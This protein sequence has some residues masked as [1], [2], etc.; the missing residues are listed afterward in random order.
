M[1]LPYV[2]LEFDK[3]EVLILASGGTLETPQWQFTANFDVSRKGEVTLHL[4]LRAEMVEPKKR[5]GLSTQRL[6][7]DPSKTS[8]DARP[9]AI[10]PVSYTPLTLPTKA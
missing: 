10:E 8:G 7:L 4:Y 3:N 2:V 9:S 6:A 5:D 1:S